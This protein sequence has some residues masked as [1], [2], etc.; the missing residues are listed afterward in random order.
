MTA[1]T[2]SRPPLQLVEGGVLPRI[3]VGIYTLEHFRTD[4]EEETIA[5]NIAACMHL[6]DLSSKDVAVGIGMSVSTVYAVLRG[7]R[8]RET[9]LVELASFFYL[10]PEDL[11]RPWGV[12]FF[13]HFKKLESWR[14]GVY[15]TLDACG[16]PLHFEEINRRL[17]WRRRM[18]GPYWRRRFTARLMAM[19][20]VGELRKTKEGLYA[21]A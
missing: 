1:A 11:K 8:V 7:R 15:T 18:K 3:H 20:D 16:E 5:K 21:L 2:K 19:V 6:R 12:D 9:T 4:T 13:T 17:H 14:D 10:K